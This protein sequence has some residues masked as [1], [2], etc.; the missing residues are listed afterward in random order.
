MFTGIIQNLGQIEKKTE[1]QKQI[2]FSFRY[3]AAKPKLNLG[4]SIA[5]N[6]VCLTV[7]KS[8]APGY[9]EADVMK[10]TIKAT[11]F[12]VLQKGATVNLERSLKYGEPLGGH[13]VTGHVD[14]VGGIQ[15][16]EKQGKNLLMWIEASNAILK[17][18][19]VKG[20]VAV[21]GI[22]LTL[23]KLS[24]NAFAVGLIPHTLKV[25][26]LGRKKVSDKVNLEID[27]VARYLAKLN[28]M[29][30]RNNK[31]VIRKKLS[32]SLLKNQGF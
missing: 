10:E 17:L 9:F 20:S 31:K 5:V 15:K 27:L 4:E 23:Q 1:N 26:N 12:A 3:L 7:S 25:T 19:A 16:I 22:S 29:L 14:G 30:K 28:P 11:S 24:R 2:R 32:L 8:K 18:L 13:F 6:G 21:D